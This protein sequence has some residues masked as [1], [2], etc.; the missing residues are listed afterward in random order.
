MSR[1]YI[2]NHVLKNIL[3]VFFAFFSQV[4]FAQYLKYS[5]EDA[6][7]F[8]DKR[9]P[10]ISKDYI[11]NQTTYTDL[12]YYKNAKVL[13]MIANNETNSQRSENNPSKYKQVVDMAFN[14]AIDCS[15]ENLSSLFAQVVG[16]NIKLECESAYKVLENCLKDAYFFNGVAKQKYKRE[17]PWYHFEE[18]FDKLDYYKRTI[19]GEKLYGIYWENIQSKFLNT[20]NKYRS[21]PSGHS[22]T[23][24]MA[25]YVFS[26]LFPQNKERIMRLA[27]N[28]ALS[29]VIIGMHH[30]SDTDASKKLANDLFKTIQNEKAYKEDF[31]KAQ[32]DIRTQNFQVIDFNYFLKP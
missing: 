24:Y 11:I 10:D 12:Q 25:A 32:I 6:K 7:V 16:V 4:I 31:L 14:Y 18:G 5:D 29:R 26:K 13:R 8:L 3:V 28:F 27:D 1:T 20:G 2:F 19:V 30:K 15:P 9:L 23:C 17:R 22:T 21:Y